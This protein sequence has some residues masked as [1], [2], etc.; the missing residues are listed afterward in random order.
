MN[1]LHRLQTR[2]AQDHFSRQQFWLLI[3]WLC[4]MLVWAIYFGFKMNAGNISGD[5]VHQ[6]TTALN[7]YDPTIFSKDYLYRDP[8]TLA[9]Y[10]PQ[11]IWSIVFFY[12]LTGSIS[13]ALAILQFIYSSVIVIGAWL[14]SRQ[15][16]RNV[17]LM[18]IMMAAMMQFAT[19][20]LIGGHSW[21][22]LRAIF[23][24]YFPYNWLLARG[25]V[26][27]FLSLV[28]ARQKNTESMQALILGLIFTVHAPTGLT[29]T[30]GA[31]PYFLWRLYGSQHKLADVLKWSFSFF[32]GAAYF[33][34]NYWV[35]APQV[36][37][38]S[39]EEKAFLYDFVQY[40][41]P[42]DYPV[43]WLKLVLRSS[44]HW[45][46]LAHVPLIV[47]TGIALAGLIK[48]STTF[49]LAAM[50]MLIVYVFALKGI[51]LALLIFFIAY[52]RRSTTDP[53]ILDVIW[54]LALI[55]FGAFSVCTWLQ[56][57][58]DI[59]HAFYRIP[60][61]I[62]DNTRFLPFLFPVVAVAVFL[63]IKV[64]RYRVV[65]VAAFLILS[66]P[67][68]G[69]FF[70]PMYQNY[71]Y[72]H[73]IRWRAQYD[74]DPHFSLSETDRL[75]VLNF[76]A[77]TPENSLFLFEDSK[78]DGWYFRLR[79]RRSISVNPSD[80]SIKY[81]VRRKELIEDW[82]KYLGIL[83]AYRQRDVSRLCKVTSNMDIDYVIFPKAEVVTDSC[84]S[85]SAT[86]D[87]GMVLSRK[88]KVVTK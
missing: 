34:W 6:I 17:W 62:I 12:W 66:I 50:G 81:F 16:S 72:A 63:V 31:A 29:L 71:A 42:D 1:Y 69:P 65:L 84:Y 70:N 59:Y 39:A 75:R 22:L 30:M 68:C 82:K 73:N 27:I 88:I 51:P 5:L 64:N 11:Q 61:F 35:Y 13:W 53:E 7:R 15:L 76:A 18:T 25:L 26:L 33:L 23:P 44:Q 9:F 45:G 67:L 14:I 36:I 2:F 43:P 19:S 52:K 48:R 21:G 46:W 54:R 4:W 8:T 86:F 85:I 40:R 24:A 32:L 83:D 37:S 49:I 60:P 87:S 47:V 56:W 80:L 38:F 78:M 79:A 3:A 77:T 58:N 74:F 55:G 41:F 28:I 57:A 10:S 20:P